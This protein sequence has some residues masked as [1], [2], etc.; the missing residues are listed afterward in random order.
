MDRKFYGGLFLITGCTLMLQVVQTRILSVVS[1]Y[2][3]AFFAISV[4]MFGITAGAVFVYLRRERFTQLTLSY[5]LAYYSAAFAIAT[6]V[7]LGAQMTLAPVVMW[8]ATAV[9]TWAQLAICMSTPFFF[10]GVVV[11]LALTRS[12]FP[13]GRVYGVDLLG[14]ASGCLG[15]L[16]VLNLTD[17]P[18][19]V[20]WVGAIAASAAMLFARSGIGSE[21][22][23]KPRFH[24]LLSRRAT[25]FGV[26]VVVAFGNGLTNYGLQPLISKGTFE[27]GNSYIFREWNTFSRVVVTPTYLDF[28]E[29]WGPSPKV[30]EIGRPIE[31]RG[32]NMDGAAGTTS[33]RFNGSFEETEFLKYDVTN[34]AY[35]LPGRKRAAIIGIGGGRDILS[36]ATFG[37]RDITGVE[38]NP[39]FTKLLTSEPGFADFTN[40]SKLEGVRLFVDDGRHWFARSREQFDVLQM[41]LIDTWAATGAG[42]FSLSENGLY[43][44]QAWKTFQD[45]LSEH[46][47]YTVSR[48]YNPA[49]PNETARMLSLAVAA[50]LERGVANPR[51]HIVLATQGRIATLLLAREPFSA[52]DLSALETAADRLGHR[53]LIKPSSTS[54]FPILEKIASATNRRWLDLYTSSFPFDLTPP[55]DDRP[56]FFNQVPLKNPIQALEIARRLVATDA[57]SGGVRDGNI[58]AT[59]TLVIL[60]LVS[61]ALVI[62][63]III[64]LRPAMRDVGRKLSLG[65]TL[66]FFL[67]GFGFMLVE[68]ALL[69]RTSVFLGHPVYSLSV[70]LLTLI[71]STGVGSFLSDKMP[72]DRP[73]RF[74]LWTLL[75]AGSI[76]ALPLSFSY[77]FP[78]LDAAGLPEK[79]LL[80]IALI[81]PTGVLMGF[82]FPNGMRLISLIDSR[83]APWFWGVNGAAG[84]LASIFAVCCNIAFGISTTLRVGAFLYL[85][86]IPA[87][88]YLL[89]PRQ[90]AVPVTTPGA[91]AVAAP[92]G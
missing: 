33:F 47:V 26:L 25:I 35:Y 68:I 13:I 48:W 4:A 66:Y 90:R 69:Q 82:A 16:L 36:A 6:F 83:P 15:A 49:N 86:L 74:V 38:L 89:M 91:A 67:I 23:Q 5:D 41:S 50:L 3:L 70:L 72:L 58:V 87:T 24:R 2:H 81:A 63:T 52:A 78:R 9:W 22:Q 73:E 55:T 43:T 60:F 1:W 65:G 17:G 84:V 76:L 7:A 45:R 64:P 20:I 53:L 37:Y 32:M 19:G 14:A 77:F 75:T 40:F 56:F 44:V 92:S 54:E 21:P 31:Q 12:P 51:A 8:S 11:S 27:S 79:I 39:V 42:A 62:A 71:L 80:C 61:L 57:R 46:G 30:A 88:I 29:M 10:S 18:S 59:A 28:P 85:M 34:L